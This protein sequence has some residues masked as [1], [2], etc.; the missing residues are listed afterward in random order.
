MRRDRRHAYRPWIVF[1]RAQT[2]PS[3]CKALGTFLLWIRPKGA[4]CAKHRETKPAQALRRVRKEPTG[5]CGDMGT[6]PCWGP[7]DCPQEHL[8]GACLL[9]SS[10]HQQRPLIYQP[11]T[12]VVAW[13]GM[14]INK[15]PNRFT[16]LPGVD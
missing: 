4:M 6:L 8:Q 14:G 12:K 1:F 10:E 3:I 13:A 16:F 15:S 5:H 11:N 7:T 9:L 2:T